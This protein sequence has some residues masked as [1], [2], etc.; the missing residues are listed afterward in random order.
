MISLYA[1][2]RV[3]GLLCTRYIGEMGKDYVHAVTPL[4]EDALIDRD[5]VH[6]QTA[7]WAVKHMALGDCSLYMW[8]GLYCCWYCRRTCAG[9]RGVFGTFDELYFPQ[10]L[11]DG[12]S[13]DTGAA[14]SGW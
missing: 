2:R 4:F 9:P 12:P 8:G 1:T 6:R 11:R 13:Y 3:T 5:L 7:T 14:L 10:Y